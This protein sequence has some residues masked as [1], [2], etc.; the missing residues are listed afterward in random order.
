[1]Q[2]AELRAQFQPTTDSVALARRLTRSLRDELPA[3]VADR[4]ELVVSELAT[5]A[6]RHAATPY[7]VSVRVF[8]TVRVEVSDASPDRPVR[9][10]DDTSEPNG[11]GLLIVDKCADRWGVDPLPSGKVVWAD[12]RMFTRTGGAGGPGSG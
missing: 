5:N 12:V 6:V 3:D 4:V 10:R 7:E 1:M 8:P 9:A 2:W 11:R